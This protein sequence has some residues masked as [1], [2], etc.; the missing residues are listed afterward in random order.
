MKRLLTIILLLFT[1]SAFAHGPHHGYWRHNGGGQWNWVAP[2]IVGG[3]IGYEM[4]RPAQPI[5]VNQ[6]PPPVIYQQQNCSPWTQI[7]NPDGTTT[8]TRTCYGVQ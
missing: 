5:V 3:V 6:L 1:A 4:G 7:Q 8:M 2:V